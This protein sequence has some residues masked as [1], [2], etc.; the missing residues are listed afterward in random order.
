VIKPT[1]RAASLACTVVATAGIGSIARYLSSRRSG[2]RPSG[3]VSVAFGKPTRMARMKYQVLYDSKPF[4]DAVLLYYANGVY[5][6]L[7]QGEHHYGA[8][9]LKGDFDH[10]SYTAHFISLPSVDWNNK[11]V[12]HVLQFDNT[13]GTFTQQLTNPDDPDVPQ[14]TG[15]FTA[16]ANPIIDPTR[17]TWDKAQSLGQ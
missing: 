7:S 17:L 16:N 14:Q 9:V 8:Y 4:P 15:T 1:K 10:P 3:V 6:I 2:S 13:S 12:Y 5:A 11:S